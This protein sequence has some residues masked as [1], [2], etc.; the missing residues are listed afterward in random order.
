MSQGECYHWHL[1]KQFRRQGLS[2]PLASDPIDQH[3]FKNFI[4][5]EGTIET[6]EKNSSEKLRILIITILALHFSQLKLFTITGSELPITITFGYKTKIV[7]YLPFS[8]INKSLLKKWLDWL[9]FSCGYGNCWNYQAPNTFP[10]GLLLP[11]SRL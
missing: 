3:I 6:T 11:S 10:T 9:N 8:S 2:F 4:F 5:I 7:N 1:F